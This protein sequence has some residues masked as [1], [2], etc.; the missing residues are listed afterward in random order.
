MRESTIHFPGLVKGFI[1]S[2]NLHNCISIKIESQVY[3]SWQCPSRIILSLVLISIPGFPFLLLF[4]FVDVLL[5]IRSETN[6]K[7]RLK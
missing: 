7:K 5:S 6:V 1:M 3:Q 2:H 4:F